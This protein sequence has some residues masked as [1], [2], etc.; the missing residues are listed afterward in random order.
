VQAERADKAWE[1]AESLTTSAL[2]AAVTEPSLA[3][4]TNA[5]KLW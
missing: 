5:L 1:T 4:Q 3:T 2:A